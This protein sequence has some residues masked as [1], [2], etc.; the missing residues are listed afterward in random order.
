PQT[1]VKGLSFES[2]DCP[3]GLVACADPEKL[4][5]ILVNLISNAVKF[6][7]TPGRV[8]LSCHAVDDRVEV[9]VRD[10]AIGIPSDRL[11]HIFDPFVQVDP[12]LTRRREGTG[13]GL[14]IS[15]DLAR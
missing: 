4:R 14:A 12:R 10:S 11:E 2:S 8:T 5:Q 6:T 7:E 1:S 15:R 13:L 3:P 9:L